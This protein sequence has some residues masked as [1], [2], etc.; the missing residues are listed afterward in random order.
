MSGSPHIPVVTD[1]TFDDMV[2]RA[3]GVVAV[4]FSAAW[5]APCRMMAPSVEALA[6]EYTGKLSIVDLDADVNPAT[7]VRFGVR[8]LPTILVFRN[9]EVVDRIVGAQQKRTLQE[10]LERQLELHATPALGAGAN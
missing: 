4:K 3:P 9:G 6:Q 2:V 8:G 1:A 5:C 10:R 7:M